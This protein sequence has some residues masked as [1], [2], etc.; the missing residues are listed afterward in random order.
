MPQVAKPRLHQLVAVWFEHLHHVDLAARERRDLLRHRP[1]GGAIERSRVD[2]GALQIVLERHPRGGHV[3][4]HGDTRSAQIAPVE[5]DVGGASDEQERIAR[6]DLADAQ[7]CAGGIGVV[8]HHHAH[9]PAPGEIHLALAHPLRGER[10]LR[11]E[12]VFDRQ[13]F[14]REEAAGQAQIERCVHHRSYALAH[15]HGYHGR[16]RCRVGSRPR[17]GSQSIEHARS[18]AVKRM[19][20][21]QPSAKIG[22]DSA[23]STRRAA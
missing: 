5:R 10:P 1:I 19:P 8:V 14:A 4:G 16:F 3:G 15:A 2:A 23:G 7:E 9:R 12:H 21:A 11:G 20:R 22:T 6:H 18:I 17:V 13:P